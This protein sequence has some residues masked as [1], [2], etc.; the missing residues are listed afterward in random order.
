MKLGYFGINMGSFATPEAC[1]K[2]ARACEAAGYESVWTGEHVVVI[3]PQQAPSP[4]PPLTP[5]LDQGI[6]L[7]WIAAQTERIRLGTGIIILPQRNP[8]ILSKEL[9]TLDHV[10]N[11]RLMVG[12]GVGYVQGEFDALGIPFEERGPRTTE[13]IEVLRAI[14]TQDQPH[15]EGQFTSFSG[16]QQRP[17]P[18][19]DPHPPIFVGGMSRPALRRAIGHGDAYYGFFQS[20]E[21]TAEL[22][23]AIREESKNTERPAALGELPITIT[24]PAGLLDHDTARRYEDLGV[25]RLVVFS[26]FTAMASSAIDP[27][28]PELDAA[29]AHIERQANELGMG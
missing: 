13:H 12:F 17:Q 22:L 20:V 1:V 27:N 6:A 9:A 11:G 16:I 23:E 14:W 26:E 8:L 19:Q 3:D 25:E 2:L 10:S 4:L 7:A 29:L 21:A 15:F 24:P 28:S 5:Q 18:L